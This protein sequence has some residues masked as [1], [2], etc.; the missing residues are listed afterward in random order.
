VEPQKTVMKEN[1]QSLKK[2]LG[3]ICS[4]SNP[5]LDLNDTDNMYIEIHWAQPNVIWELLIHC[6]VYICCND[7]KNATLILRNINFNVL[8]SKFVFE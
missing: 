7:H 8:F 1:A 3:F 4:L 6:F 2:I 5:V